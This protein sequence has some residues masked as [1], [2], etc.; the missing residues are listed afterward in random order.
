MGKTNE[1]IKECIVCGDEFEDRTRPGN[2]K[3]CSRKCADEARK[4]RQRKQ[5]RNENPP[6]PNQ[7]QRYYADHFIYSFWVDNRIG[8]N[9]MWKEAAPYSPD[10][11]DNIINARELYERIGGRKRHSETID[12]DGDEGGN[13]GVNVQFVEHKREPSEVVTYQM[14][15]EELAEYIAKKKRNI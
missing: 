5:Y 15:D 3:S 13:H 14:S 1:R 11:I 12:Y 8:R 4:A 2:K 7:R 10:K 9:Q 6:Q